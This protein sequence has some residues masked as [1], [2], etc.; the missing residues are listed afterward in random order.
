VSDREL[1]ITPRLA[2]QLVFFLIVIPLLPILISG[3][4][5]WWEAWT[6]AAVNVLGF[7]ASRRLAARRHPDLLAERARSMGLADAKAWDKVLA[8]LVSLGLGLVLAMAGLDARLGWTPGFPLWARLAALGL[9]LLGYA[10]GSWALI[11]N[12]FFSG[13][14]RIQKERGHHVVSTGPYRWMRHPGYAGALLTYVVTP[15][16]LESLPAFVPAIL[17][18]AVLVVR[19]ALEDK[20]LQAELPGYAEYAKRTRYRLVPGIW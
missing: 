3:H 12:R 19:T 11:E 7:A 18:V 2:L 8:P 17:L 20:T 4:W 9:I 5:S 15:V 10:F 14:V 16:F 13:V 1:R 6:F